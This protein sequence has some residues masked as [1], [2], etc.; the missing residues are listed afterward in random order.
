MG[1]KDGRVDAYIAKSAKFAQ[2]I[3][4]RLR[5]IVH[6]ACPDV[7]ET[8]KWKFPNF[9]YNGMLCNMAAFKQHCAFG[10]WHKAIRDA[11]SGG[12]KAKAMG[13]LGRITSLDD[14]PSEATLR[15]HIKQA[16]RLNDAGVKSTRPRPKAKEPVQIPDD[17]K[18]ALKSHK[19]AGST[20]EAFSPSHRREYIEWI[21]EAKQPATRHR[22]IATML[23]WLAEGK[24]RNWKYERR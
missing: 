24:S 8:I 9:M 10:F 17:V 7:E 13:Q 15:R 2:P 12:N 11:V 23:E 19:Q 18:R 14:L 22:R 16:M 6:S 21:T 1:K 5:D 3:L 4:R 20:F